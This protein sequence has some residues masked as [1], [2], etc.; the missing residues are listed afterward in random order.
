VLEVEELTAPGLH[1]I[2]FSVGAGEIVGVA[3]VAETA[4]PSSW[5]RLP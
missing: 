4:N 1:D 2:N 3:G 5:Q